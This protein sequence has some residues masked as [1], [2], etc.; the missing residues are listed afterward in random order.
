VSRSPG[1]ESFVTS[2]IHRTSLVLR[3]RV[4][5]GSIR[6]RSGAGPILTA[7]IAV[8]LSYWIAHLL[9]GHPFPFFAPVCAWICLGF[10]ADRNMRRVAEVGIGVAIGVGLGEAIA[11][12]IGAGAIQIGVVLVV[13]AL[14]ARFIDRGA[15]LTTQAGVQSIVIVGLPVMSTGGGGGLGRWTDALVGA[16]VAFV[17]AALTPGD[18]RRLPRRLGGEGLSELARTFEEIAHGMR[19]GEAADREAA[20]VRGRASEPALDE[21]QSVTKD[22]LGTAKVTA[23][24]R[25]YRAELTVMGRT[26]ML[27]DRTMRTV[28]VIARRALSLPTGPEVDRLAQLLD[29]LA[30]A[31]HLLAENVASGTEPAVAREMLLGVAHEAHP[32]LLGTGDW[33][34]Q[35]ITLILRSAI[36]DLCETAGATPGEARDALAPM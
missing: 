18:P 25:R 13:S 10:T 35:S 19:T 28:R 23:T 4:R 36:V 2:A 8:S 11:S 31:T 5:Q 9:L 34:V 22:A 29:D 32:G 26:A 1:E 12:F 30:K 17:V 3:S 15:L 24:G 33:Q 7:G 27:G 21:W 14:V 6:V 16:A 20:L